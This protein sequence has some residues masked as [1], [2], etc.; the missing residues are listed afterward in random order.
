MAHK[1]LQQSKIMPSITQSIAGTVAKHVRPDITKSGTGSCLT[2]DVVHGLAGQGLGALWDVLW[3][4]R[5]ASFRERTMR[6]LPQ[7]HS[8]LHLPVRAARRRLKKRPAS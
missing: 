8:A 3:M 1:V 6:E 4:M 2:D 7:R 5:R